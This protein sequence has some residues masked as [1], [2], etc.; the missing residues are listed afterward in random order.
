MVFSAFTVPASRL[1]CVRP[2]FV[3]FL[4]PFIGRLS[5]TTTTKFA[6]A[7]T[8]AALGFIVMAAAALLA[9]TGDVSMAWLTVVRL[10][11]DQTGRHP[12]V[13]WLVRVGPWLWPREVCSRTWFP[14]GGAL[15]PEGD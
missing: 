4:A 1:P 6:G 3:L 5:A 13:Q 10:R 11:D 14:P 12:P 15:R 7:L 2:L 9:R 8:A